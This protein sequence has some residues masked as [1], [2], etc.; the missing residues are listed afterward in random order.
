MMHATLRFHGELAGLVRRGP[1][2][3]DAQ[4]AMT[5][6][7]PVNRRASLKDVA[8]ALGVPHA[9][10][11][12]LTVNGRAADFNHL[13]AAGESVE[14]RPGEPPVDVLTPTMLRPQALPAVRFAADGNVGK[15]GR[16]L[17]LLGFDALPCN[18]FPDAAIAELAAAEGRI[19]LSSDRRL[20]RRSKIVWG[21]LIRD[22]DPE[23]Q[24]ADILAFFGLGGPYAPF[25]R[26]LKCNVSLAPVAKAEV[27]HLLEPKTRLYYQDFS[28]C[29]ACG[30]VYWA[31]SHVER[32]HQRLAAMGLAGRT[33]PGA[34]F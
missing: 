3:V 32:L 18:D 22:H 1:R 4:G 11:Y 14:V 7:Y 34:R 20:L 5:V 19:V 23:A 30:R 9:E 8:E 21:R 31:G 13:L 28:R 17:C 29:P 2:I 33:A 12:G 10:V 27:L 6:P 25:S 16:L 15:L 24:L 26:C